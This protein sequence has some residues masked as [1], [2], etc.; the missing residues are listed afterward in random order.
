VS[1]HARTSN[2]ILFSDVHL[3]ADLVQHVRPWTRKRLRKIAE[4]DRDLSAM[5]DHYRENAD[6]DRPWRLI[7]AGD[8]V[9]FI[10]MSI[11]PPDAE[12]GATSAANLL[13]T[14]EERE[15]GLGSTAEHAVLKMRAVARRHSGVFDR[16][17][18]FVA[19]GHSVALVRGNHD[20]EFHWEAARDALVEAITDRAPDGTDRAVLAKRITVY[21]WFYYE[22]GLLYVEHGHQFDAMCSYH[23]VLNPVSPLDPKR[24][25]WSFADLLLRYVVRPTP[26]LHSHGHEDMGFVDYLR[27]AWSF[28]PGGAVGLAVRYLTATGRALRRWRAHL[29]VTAQALRA[30]HERRMEALASRHHVGIGVV[31]S[32]AALWPTPVTRGGFAVLR[33]MFLDRIAF[34]LL[35]GLL[36]ILALIFLPLLWG[37]GTTVALFLALLAVTQVTERFRGPDLDPAETMRA[38]ARHIANILPTRYVVMGH[39]H[40]PKMID[41]GNDATYVNLGNWGSDELDDKLG[42]SRTHLVLRW[43]DGELETEFLRWVPGLGPE[44]VAVE[45]ESP[46]GTLVA[47]T[48]LDAAPNG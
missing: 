17:A 7:I 47:P 44:L 4:V 35:A 6:P 37:A 12:D 31:R 42:A 24:I 5:L 15:H 32:L 39:T 43:L 40:Q 48:F 27:V 22:E 13:L 10:G 11:A 30:E 23:H 33:S 1:P 41:V 16:L 8:L 29:G 9:D 2:Y 38:A 46:D 28:G 14:A 34:I 26:G 45:L 36:S 25:S 18:A 3:G 20:V 21:P 19:D